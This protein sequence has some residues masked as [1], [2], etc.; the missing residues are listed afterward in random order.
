MIVLV[1]VVVI[2]LLV[3]VA[4]GLFMYRKYHVASSGK[5]LAANTGVDVA[6]GDDLDQEG[7]Y[8]ETTSPMEGAY[9]GDIK[10]EE[11]I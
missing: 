6:S 11:R 8:D 2:L 3:L 5:D 1:V 7:V 10:P 4:G 9:T